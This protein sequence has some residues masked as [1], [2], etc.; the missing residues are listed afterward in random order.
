MITHGKKKLLIALLMQV[1][2]GLTQVP[3]IGLLVVISV[4]GFNAGILEALHVTARNGRPS[5]GLLFR[6]LTSGTHSGRLL[7]MGALVFVVG[8]ISVLGI[9]SGSEELLDPEL[10]SQIEQGD[11]EAINQLDQESLGKMVL[12]FVIGVSISGTL[13]YFTIPLMWFGGRKLLPA[14]DEGLK[15]LFINWKAFL[16]LG[17]GLAAILVPVA[18]VTGILFALAGKGGALSM[19]VMAVI[20]ILL[21]AFQLLLFGTQYCAYRDIFGI[22]DENKPPAPEDDSQLLA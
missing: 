11:M 5:P 16:V 6:P 9:M 4:P 18:V 7:A 17:L 10:M 15:A 12:A 20:M 22:E 19:I 13:S 3:L 1:I 14:L 2:M 21:L 8:V